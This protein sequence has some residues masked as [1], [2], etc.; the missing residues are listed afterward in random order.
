[1]TNLRRLAF[2]KPRRKAKERKPIKR[3]KRPRKQRKTSRGKIGRLADKL[4]SLVVRK[5]GACEAGQ[6]KCAGPL[7]CAHIV[8]RSYR[9]TRWAEDNAFAL[10]AAAH[11]YFTHH[12][13]EWEV[14]VE[15]AIGC[16]NYSQIKRRALE[17]W[18]GD[19]EGVLVRL[20]AR[21]VALGIPADGKA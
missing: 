3:T 9:S 2:A 19:L 16:E 13:L 1:M 18:D 17:K 21:A 8:S 10:C 14:F 12:P 15:T 5:R 20:A 7:Q 6:I 11:T 4:F